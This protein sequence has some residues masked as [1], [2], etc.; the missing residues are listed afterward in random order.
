VE[1]RSSPTRS[2]KRRWRYRH[3]RLDYRTSI[4]L[5]PP[6]PAGQFFMC[7]MFSFFFW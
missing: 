5:F 6:V 1:R 4:I 7:L 3:R 2:C